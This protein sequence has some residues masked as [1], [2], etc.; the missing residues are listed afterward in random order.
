[1][2]KITQINGL[3]QEGKTTELVGIFVNHF[4]NSGDKMTPI[5]IVVGSTAESILRSIDECLVGKQITIEQEKDLKYVNTYIVPTKFGIDKLKE[6]IYDY[7]EKKDC[8]FYID[9][10]DATNVTVKDLESLQDS[11]PNPLCGNSFDIYYTRTRVKQDV[12]NTNDIP[13]NKFYIEDKDGVTLVFDSLALVTEHVEQKGL[14]KLNT[15]VNLNLASGPVIIPNPFCIYVKI[16][17]KW[18]LDPNYK[19]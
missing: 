1:M 9:D 13:V 16:D 15:V 7:I 2:Q 19:E 11:Y 12:E 4:I 3:R 17:G 18:V 14:S 8:V 10:L 6:L 5:L